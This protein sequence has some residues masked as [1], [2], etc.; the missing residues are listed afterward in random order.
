M[1]VRAIA[2]MRGCTT[3]RFEWI[4]ALIQIRAKGRMDNVHHGSVLLR[5]R[6]RIRLAVRQARVANSGLRNPPRIFV[7]TRSAAAQTSPE[8]QL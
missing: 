3:V 4:I 7:E 8:V 1:C 2:R 5:R 6:P